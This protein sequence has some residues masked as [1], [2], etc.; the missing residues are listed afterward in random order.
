MAENKNRIGQGFELNG[1]EATIAALGMLEEKVGQRVLAAAVKKASKPFVKAARRRAPVQPGLLKFS[2]GSVTRKYKAAGGRIAVQIMGPRRGVG[3]KKAATIRGQAGNE[4]REPANY[5]HLV[6]FGTA[7]HNVEHKQAAALGAPGG[8]FDNVD[9]Y[10]AGPQPF[11]RNAW[12]ATV[13]TM[14]K[15]LGQELDK[16]IAKAAAD[17]RQKSRERRTAGAVKRVRKM[18]AKMP[19][20]RSFMGAI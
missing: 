18:S 12:S 9:I 5:A 13:G 2:M 1:M 3:G 20:A 16:G 8:P 15:I 17:A 14:Q 10:G 6:E 7:A 4:S 11:M 19:R